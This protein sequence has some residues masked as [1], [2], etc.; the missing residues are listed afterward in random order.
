MWLL[1][2]IKQRFI[3]SGPDMGR[4]V[5]LVMTSGG[6]QT[7]ALTSLLGMCHAVSYESLYG[8][9]KDEDQRGQCSTGLFQFLTAAVQPCLLTALVGAAC[10]FTLHC[11]NVMHR[12]SFS[13]HHGCRKQPSGLAASRVH[14]LGDC[15]PRYMAE[16]GQLGMQQAP[17]VC[18]DGDKED[19]AR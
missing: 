10:I 15:A 3:G 1:I 5:Q 2:S 6:A 14:K 16:L 11:H 12:R 9:C 18:A 8:M 17:T 7:A 13:C 4:C 19:A